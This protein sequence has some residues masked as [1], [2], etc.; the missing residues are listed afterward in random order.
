[1]KKQFIQYRIICK[2]VCNCSVIILKMMEQE[3][4]LFKLR[5]VMGLDFATNTVVSYEES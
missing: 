5:M 1:M 3:N 2:S 4:K